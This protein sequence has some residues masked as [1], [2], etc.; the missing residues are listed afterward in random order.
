MTYQASIKDS[1]IIVFAA[2][3]VANN[4]TLYLFYICI[5]NQIYV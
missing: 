2:L 4:Y 1:I 3:A 5:N